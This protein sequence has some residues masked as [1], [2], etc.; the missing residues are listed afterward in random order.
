MAP[1]SAGGRTL[2]SRQYKSI[3]LERI[4]SCQMSYMN[5][6]VS[7][8]C[9]VSTVTPTSVPIRCQWLIKKPADASEKNWHKQL[10]FFV[11]FVSIHHILAFPIYGIDW[12]KTGREQVTGFKPGS[13]ERTVVYFVLRGHSVA[14]L[15]EALRYKPE[16]RGFDS[17][18]CISN[19]STV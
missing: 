13:S 6:A 19:F 16:G 4:C 18:C 7:G 9:L 3:L 17:R 15:V 14:Q 1:L 2:T 12:R 5:W 11:H 10:R 8:S